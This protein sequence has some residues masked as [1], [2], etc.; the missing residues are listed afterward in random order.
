MDKLHYLFFAI[1]VIGMFLGAMGVIG[2]QNNSNENLIDATNELII[3]VGALETDRDFHDGF[4][5]DL[6]KNFT[7]LENQ[8]NETFD[9]FQSEIVKIKNDIRNKFPH[10]SDVEQEEQSVIAD[11]PFLTLK[12]DQ[13]EFVLGEPITFRGIANPND[14]ILITI[15][16]P[17]RSLYQHAVSK[18]DIINGQYVTEYPTSFDDP[19][20]TWSAY[21][22]QQSEQTKTL[23]FKVE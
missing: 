3:R 14:A 22:R 8:T 16:K 6:G 13:S 1:A 15:K 17:D 9:I 7:A 10:G 4:I 2:A 19:P 5:I 20:G 18:T 11:T 23:T 12:I 21:A